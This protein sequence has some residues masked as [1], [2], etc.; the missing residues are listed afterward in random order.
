MHDVSLQ[1]C[2]AHLQCTSPL[3]AIMLLK[4][5]IASS[6]SHELLANGRLHYLKQ[7]SHLA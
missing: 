5:C 2:K 4:I 3:T 1:R 7:M 6:K